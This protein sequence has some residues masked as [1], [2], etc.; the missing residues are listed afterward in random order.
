MLICQ[1]KV[2]PKTC[3]NN[4][5]GTSVLYGLFL[6][7]K[8]GFPKHFKCVHII[9]TTSYHTETNHADPETFKF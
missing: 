8:V 7:T 6:S 9:C 4:S 5:R 3:T 2:V 1:K